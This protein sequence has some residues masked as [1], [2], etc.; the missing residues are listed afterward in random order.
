MQKKNYSFLQSDHLCPHL[1][2]SSDDNEHTMTDVIGIGWQKNM[3]D[4]LLSGNN[5]CELR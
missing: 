5:P 3:A 4:E 1:P 2:P